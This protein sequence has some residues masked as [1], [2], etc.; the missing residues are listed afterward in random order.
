MLKLKKRNFKLKG[1]LFVRIIKGFSKNK[2]KIQDRKQA[3]Q[4]V[5][6]YSD[7]TKRDTMFNL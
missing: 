3:Y 1:L 2:K 6:N 4:K 5:I 7:C